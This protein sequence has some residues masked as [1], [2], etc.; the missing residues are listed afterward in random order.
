MT[1]RLLYHFFWNFYDYLGSYL[2]LGGAGFLSICVLILAGGALASVI[3]VAVVQ[4]IVALLTAV[5]LLVLTSLLMG[6]TFAFATRAARDEP[7]RLPDFR[8]GVRP[9]F[10]AYLKLLICL[11]LA[12]CVILSNIWFYLHLGNTVASPA[13]R[14]VLISAAMVFLWGAVGVTVYGFCALA[15]PAR[16]P[17]EKSLRPLLRRATMLFALAPGLWVAVAVIYALI[18]AFCFL[19]VVGAIF[20]LPVLASLTTTALDLVVRLVDDLGRA[21]AELGEGRPIGVYKRRALE[22]GWEWEHRQPR[23][24][25]RELIKPWEA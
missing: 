6:G 13:V 3:P 12:E 8:G 7:A 5:A 16:F 1:R 9:L 21:R 15:T 10:P 14:M 19:S 20:L 23:R 24:T 18:A 25:L 2:L 17:E 11:G 22:L 4:G